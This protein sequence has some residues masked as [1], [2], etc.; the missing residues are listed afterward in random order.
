ML[1]VVATIS[2]NASS[3]P[4]IVV[5]RTDSVVGNYVIFVPAS[6]GN[7][8]ATV[9]LESTS[10]ISQTCASMSWYDDNNNPQTSANVCSDSSAKGGFVLPIRAK[11]GTDI[12]LN[13]N[14]S[15]GSVYTTLERL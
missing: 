1:L 15:S 6:S 7:F 3:Y 8:R 4:T 11:A 10:G 9:Y 14:S 12:W 13:V 2:L 5:R